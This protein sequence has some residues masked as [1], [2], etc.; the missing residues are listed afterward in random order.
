[1]SG[2]EDVEDVRHYQAPYSSK[3]PIPTI[4]KYR[5]ERAARQQEALRDDD[6]VDSQGPSYSGRGQPESDARPS[7]PETSQ[8]DDARKDGAI[9]EVEDIPQDTSQVDPVATDPKRRRKEMKDRKK[10]RADREVTDP[11]THLPVTVH[12]FTDEALEE[13][14]FN[15][16]PSGST[17]ETAT[18]RDAK[19]KSQEQLNSERA[20]L[21]QDHDL[22]TNRFPP[23]DFD[24]LSN[25]LAAISRRGVTIG[26]LELSLLF[27]EHWRWK[28]SYVMP[29]PPVSKKLAVSQG[30]RLGLP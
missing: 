24:V 17:S 10:E 26:L 30:S 13:L 25:Q 14:D 1:M 27:W 8:Q 5:E 4:S 2:K 29:S 6:N 19:E 3:R 16:R 12:D 23:P 20:D 15:Q 22:L 21:Q 11:I 7:T 28:G 18:G 9:N